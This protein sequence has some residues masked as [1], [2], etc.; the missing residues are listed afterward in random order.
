MTKPCDYAP[1][2]SQTSQ[3]K[4]QFFIFSFFVELAYKLI[5]FTEKQAH[6][7]N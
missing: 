1:G 2:A 4:N 3:K 6:N 5:N 7:Q